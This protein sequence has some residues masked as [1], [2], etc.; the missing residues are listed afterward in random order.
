MD[1][2]KSEELVTN[3]IQIHRHHKR[4]PYA[5]NTFPQEQISWNCDDSPL[6]YYGKAMPGGH[7]AQVH[8]QLYTSSSNP[9]APQGFPNSTCQF[10]QITHG[11]F[12]DSAQHGL[13]LFEVYHDELNF[14]PDGATNALNYR[15]TNNVITSQVAGMV[16]KAM[17]PQTQDHDFAV[18][19]Q[20]ASVDSLEPAYACSYASALYSSYAVGSTNPGWVTHLNEAQELYHTLD[21]IS[22]IDPANAG[23]QYVHLP[24]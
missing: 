12:Q 5:S 21:L 11:G 15:V 8:W 19:I 13:D 17:Y 22:G 23:W 20:P 10:P 2:A 9:L 6:F 4:T 14:L 3:V 1:D 18:R 24:G 16:I 7:P